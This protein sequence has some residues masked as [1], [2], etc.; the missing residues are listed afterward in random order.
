[1]LLNDQTILN[2]ELNIFVSKVEPCYTFLEGIEAILYIL[3]KQAFFWNEEIL[4]QL[5]LYET[6]KT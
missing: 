3:K 4:H 6:Q 2:T 1:M 5:K